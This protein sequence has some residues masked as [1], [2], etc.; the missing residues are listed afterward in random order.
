LFDRGGTLTPDELVTLEAED[1]RRSR[2]F[3]AS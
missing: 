1:I 3:T 2:V